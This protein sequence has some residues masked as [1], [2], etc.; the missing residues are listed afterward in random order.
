MCRLVGQVTGGGFEE[1]DSVTRGAAWLAIACMCTWP[2]GDEAAA[3]G[4]HPESAGEREVL[5]V[6]VGCSENVNFG[7]ATASVQFTGTSGITASEIGTRGTFT[8]EGDGA[9][10]A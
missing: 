9:V 3:R 7:G 4:R 5:Y 2:W 8:T 10:C 1:V 6:G